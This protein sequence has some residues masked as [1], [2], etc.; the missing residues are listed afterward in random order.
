MGKKRKTMLE[1]AKEQS[2][3][4]G[5]KRHWLD[6]Q[7]QELRE[8]LLALQTAMNCGELANWRPIDVWRELIV[9]EGIDLGVRFEEFRRWLRGYDGKEKT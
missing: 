4:T 1:K 6:R 3:P 5:R 7:P 9:A 8:E 2:V